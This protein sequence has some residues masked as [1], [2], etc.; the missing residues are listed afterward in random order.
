MNNNNY[1]NFNKLTSKKKSNYLTSFAI[2]DEYTRI[3]ITQGHL[4]V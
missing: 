4:T 1:L 3:F 2:T